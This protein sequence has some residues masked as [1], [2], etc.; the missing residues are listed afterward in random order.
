MWNYH[1][2][3][4][5]CTEKENTKKTK[6]QSIEWEKIFISHISDKWLITKIYKEFLQLNRKKNQS[7]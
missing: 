5:F 4:S 1:K 3:K 6:R 2:L 7:D